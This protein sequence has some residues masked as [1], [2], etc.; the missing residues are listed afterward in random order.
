MGTAP[1]PSDAPEDAL[2]E[3]AVAVVLLK[4]RLARVKEEIRTLND[5][6][7]REQRRWEAAR[8]RRRLAY[9]RR[10]CVRL[11]HQLQEVSDEYPVSYLRVMR[12][13]A[14]HGRPE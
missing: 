14:H 7:R 8:T 3:A 4:T 1:F 10:R 6:T 2:L 5:G 11:T 12:A 9:W 13:A